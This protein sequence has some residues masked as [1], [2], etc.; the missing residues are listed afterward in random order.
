M[1]SCAQTLL[2]EK[3]MQFSLHKKNCWREM[4]EDSS[5]GV[6]YRCQSR[7]LLPSSNARP[8]A[9]GHTAQHLSLALLNQ[10]F[11]KRMACLNGAHLS[12]VLPAARRRGSS[13]QPVIWSVVF[14]PLCRTHIITCRPPF[15]S[16][17]Y[18][19]ETMLR[20]I[21]FLDAATCTAVSTP[22][23]SVMLMVSI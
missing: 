10:A 20:S 5:Q 19:F 7:T 2:F 18:F 16:Q 11:P 3:K 1:S 13:S 12:S 23:V 8:L 22:T 14:R 6:P 15:L 4:A 9:G 17:I 21:P